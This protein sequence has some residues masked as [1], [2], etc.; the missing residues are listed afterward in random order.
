M[1]SIINLSYKYYN[2]ALKNIKSNNISNA[3]DNLYKAIKLYNEDI[4]ILNLL[5]SCEYLLC[6]FDK[7]KYS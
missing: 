7:S 2:E 4:D 6:N 1:D 5:G 3:R